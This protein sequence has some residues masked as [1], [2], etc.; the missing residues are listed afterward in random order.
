MTNFNFQQK[1]IVTKGSLVTKWSLKKVGPRPGWSPLKV[2][3]NF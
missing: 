1:H 3:Q 2:F